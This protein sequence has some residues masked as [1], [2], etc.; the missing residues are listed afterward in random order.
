MWSPSNVYAKQL[1]CCISLKLVHMESQARLIGLF[2]SLPEESGRTCTWSLFWKG[3]KSPIER[4]HNSF[5]QVMRVC[6]G[7]KITYDLN[8]E[9]LLLFDLFHLMSRLVIAVWNEVTHCEQAKWH[10]TV[11]TIEI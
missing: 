3:W 11:H 8:N 10:V 5:L 7:W 6:C 4:V 2:Q 1:Y 9:Y